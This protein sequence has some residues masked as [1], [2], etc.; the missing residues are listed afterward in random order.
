MPSRTHEHGDGDTSSEAETCCKVGRTATG[1]GI[2]HR[3]SELATLRRDGT[4][5]REITTTFNTW[6]VKEVLEGENIGDNRSVHAVL[7]GENTAGEIYRVLRSNGS[8]DVR[9]TE[10]R[11]RLSAV[12]IDVDDLE[13]SFVSHVT[14]RSH[15]QNCVGIDPDTE[16]P[17]FKKT[18]NT[19]QRAKV[20][21]TNVIESTLERAVKHGQI[22]VGSLRV[23]LQVKT[24]CDKCGDTLYLSELL[25][26]RRCSCHAPDD[27][28]AACGGDR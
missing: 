7:V 22:R 14:M 10:L 2:D 5:F 16:P 19:A 24:A 17:E 12:G 11:A 1:Y 13:S 28:R 8:S 4:S 15:L 26:R 21:A 27:E 18:V 23:E 6:V 3:L 20:R 25:D 9:R